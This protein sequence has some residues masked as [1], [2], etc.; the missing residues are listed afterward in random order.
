MKVENK[1]LTFTSKFTNFEI[2]NSEFIRCKCY[3][4]A[5][6]DNANGSDITMK[7]IDRAIE[8]GEFNNKPVVAHLY[9]D[10]DGSY[11]VGG[12][13][14]KWVITNTSMEIVNECIPFGTIPESANIHKEEV[15]EADGVTVNTYVV[16]DIILWTGRFNIM[17]AAYSDDVYFNQSCEISINDYTYKDNDI[18]AIDDFTFSALCLL[19]K[20]DNPDKNVRPCFGSCRVERIKSFSLEEDSFKHN[21]ELLLENYNKFSTDN[22][23]ITNKN[24][25]NKK[26]DNL[27]NFTKINE[28]LSTVKYEKSG[29]E[30]NKYRLLNAT[31]DKVLALDME[32]YKA[33]S[34]DYAL[35]TEDEAEKLVIDF[36]SKV[37]MSLSATDKI[38]VEGFEEFS[39]N[40]EIDSKVDAQLDEYAKV[41]TAEFD[42]KFEELKQS[43]EELA[44]SYRVA[45]EKL[46]AYEA[47]EKAIAEE[48]HKKAIEEVFENYAD[49]LRNCPDFL[50]YK[51]KTEPS[52]VTID[53]VNEKLT[54]MVG[55]YVLD[56][57]TKKNFSYQP[58]SAGVNKYDAK[59][60]ITKRYG[61]LLDKY[62]N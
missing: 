20:S 12:H 48:N 60:E 1:S 53:E 5:S 61:N 45:S 41:L 50:I 59:D 27:M 51:A 19:N 16:G 21:Y 11:R 33:Y 56:T 34:F 25:N 26:E 42:K 30:V 58:Q 14:S 9:K 57:Q 23:N 3:M 62:M 43:Y 2:V 24:L 37:E 54:L 6:G 55:K 22:I 29:V 13:D 18:L 46:E 17:D 32:D 40:S 44:S 8:R 35:V 39:I 52:K 47:K 49:R 4:L 28:T 38:E 7:A 31:D 36:D 15:L 10:D